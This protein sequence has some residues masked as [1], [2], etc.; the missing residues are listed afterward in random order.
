MDQVRESL[1]PDLTLMGICLTRFVERSGVSQQ[2]RAAIEQAYPGMLLPDIPQLA[3]VQ[4]AEAIGSDVYGLE[5]PNRSTDMMSPAT[6]AFI[7]LT[8]EVIK[9]NGKAS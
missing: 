5:A 3:I 7:A 1:N 6:Q 2:T 9:R 4:R 8:K